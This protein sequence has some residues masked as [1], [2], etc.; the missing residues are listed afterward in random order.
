MD[1]TNLII[2]GIGWIST[3]TFLISIVLPARVRLHQWGI[4]TSVAT[5]IY[6]FAHGATAI[7]V[8]WIIAFF[9]HF[10][11]WQKLKKPCNRNKSEDS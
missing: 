8:K 5:G 4:F 9:F 10:Y 3:A 2:E 7:W 11:M 1:W 6:A